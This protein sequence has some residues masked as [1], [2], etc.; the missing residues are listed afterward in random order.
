MTGNLYFTNA[1]KTQTYLEVLRLN[2]SLR[3]VL[4]KTSVDR[5]RDL[6]VSPKLRYLFW[7]DGGQTPK[8]ERA[9][10]DGQN[11]TVLASE[12]LASP[13]G[14][15]VDYTNNF[16]YWTDDV[17]DMISCMAADGSQRQIVRYG[18]RYPAPYGVSIFGNYM[19]WVDRRLEKVFQASKLPGNTDAAEVIR[20]N[21]AG[22]ADVVVFDS[23]VQ[24]VAAN[25]VGFNPCQDDN[26]R[27]SQL[28]F[29][30]PE[31]QVPKCRCAHGSILS[32][33]VSCGFGSE[34]YLI[35]TTDYTLNSARLDPE[36]H[37]LPFRAISLG[38]SVMALDFD[39]RDK[40][41]YFARSSGVGRSS[42]GYISTT[43]PT[44]RPIIIAPGEILLTYFR[45]FT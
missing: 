35:F 10:L 7:T 42:I 43:S 40:R 14:L 8:I 23:H 29:A 27:C 24:P 44:S 41:V 9:Q 17:L 21:L 36:D 2:T 28:C 6:A 13:R 22:L 32:N 19:V 16:L 15:T 30:L 33:G 20:D 37:S 31:N 5:P 34:E 18:S 38:Y 26:G 11:R 45:N 3:L 4:L 25:L 39:F 1:F 12:S